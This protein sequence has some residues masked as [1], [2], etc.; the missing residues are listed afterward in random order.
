MDALTL[1]ILTLGFLFIL[2][3]IAAPGFFLAP[4]GI[5]LIAAGG[6]NYLTDSYLLSLTSGAVVTVLAVWI[7]KSKIVQP[8]ATL[9]NAAALVGK[10]AKVTQNIEPG[11]SGLIK[12]EGS[13]W[14]AVMEEY[15]NQT[16]NVGDTVVV[17]QIKGAYATVRAAHYLE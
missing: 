4:I 10:K 13:T 8:P 3:E 15:E 16:L 12:L 7:F 17:T 9:D 6:T 2:F 5:G 11:E 1:I 14:S